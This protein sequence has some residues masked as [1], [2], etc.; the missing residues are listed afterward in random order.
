MSTLGVD[1]LVER[2]APSATDT[3]PIAALPAP[4]RAQPG[5]E[6]GHRELTLQAAHR[7]GI[8]Y[9]AGAPVESVAGSM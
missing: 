4:E 7:L 9:S 2:G 5:K 3:E 8:L 6:A 1:P